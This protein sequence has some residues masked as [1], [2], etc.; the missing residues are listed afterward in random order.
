MPPRPDAPVAVAAPRLEA[1]RFASA[2]AALVYALATLSL[3]YPALVGRFLVSPHSDQFKA[4]Y[5]FREFAAASLRAGQGFPEWNPYLF[6]GLPYIGGMHGDIFYPTF[7]LRML[8]PTDLAM[9]WGMISHVF[10]AGL[11]AYWFLRALGVGFHGALIGGLAY[12]ISGPIGGLV[13]PG[14][15]GKIFVSALLP[16]SLWQLVLAIRRA[17]LSIRRRAGLTPSSNRRFDAPIG[18]GR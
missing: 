4:G 15:D 5:A 12:C 8:L 3:A 6:G 9:T 14:H 18:R 10:L 17:V 1:P 2:W 11:F 16:L 7:L 13:S